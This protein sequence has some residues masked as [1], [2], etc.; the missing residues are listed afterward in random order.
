MHATAAD[1]I[2]IADRAGAPDWTLDEALLLLKPVRAAAQRA[3]DV[4]DIVIRQITGKR[5]RQR[6][7][8]NEVAGGI[9]SPA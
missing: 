5:K 6:P 8:G 4:A 9:R 2:V 7:L 1:A 3:T